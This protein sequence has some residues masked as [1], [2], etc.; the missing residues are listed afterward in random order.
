[1]NRS[2]VDFNKP[3]QSIQ[4]KIVLWA[5]LCLLLAATIILGYSIYVLRQ[6]SIDAAN[7]EALAI[8]EAQANDVKSQMEVPL[9]TAR[10]LAASFVAI[11]DPNIPMSLTRDQANA[12]LRKVLVDN[13]SFLGTY[14]AWEPNAF[15]GLD[16]QFAGKPNHDN[17][18]RFIPYWVRGNDGSIHV[19]ALIEYET[20]GIGDWYLLPRQN[21]KEYAFAPLIYPVQGKDTIMA[22]FIVP[23]MQGDQF[24]GIT[25]VDF[26]IGFVQQIVDNVNLYDGTAQAILLTDKGELIAVRNQPDLV[27]KSAGEI[28]KNFNF[29]DALQQRIAN[30]EAFTSLSPDGKYLLAF[31]PIQIGATGTYWS[32]GLIIP[33]EKITAT[34]T[35]TA[36]NQTLIGIGLMVI[37]LAL[38]WL[39]AS[40]I[41]RPIR[42]LTEAATEISR[43]RL[44]V[45]AEVMS[46]DETG[47]LASTFNQ[48]VTQ[49]NS[50]VGAL[51]KRVGE[52]TAELAAANERA[53]RRAKQFE[54]IA[55]VSRV[56][57]QTQGL[58]D[59]LPQITQ[60]ISQ[61]FG[62]YHIGIF[63][64]D[65][66]R[67]YAVLVAANSEGGERMLARNHQLKIGQ[68]GIVGNVAGTGN[69]RIALDTGADAIYFNNPDLP[70]TR[71]ELALPLIHGGGQVVGVLDVQSTDSNAFGQDDVQ[72][73]STLAE[74][75]SIAIANAQLY[76]DT[77]K[78]VVEAEISYRRELHS[79]WDK[80][81]RS[82]KIAGIHRSGIK[83]NLLITPMELPGAAEVIRSGNI[84]QKK[85][86]KN[87][88]SSQMTLPVKLRGE[89]VGV[90][91]VKVE[92]EREWS[93][94]EID[95]VT[96]ILERAA[97]AVESSRLL[98]ESRK[99]AEK[100]RIIGEISTKVSSFTNRNNI[101]QAAVSEI[102][103]VLPGAEV[104]I[105]LQNKD[106]KDNDGN[107]E[108]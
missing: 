7:R 6:T 96:A 88:K 72:V 107:S 56:I 26:P 51:E 10:T 17:T 4:L 84:Y 15:D 99:V 91:N 53:E 70:E 33:F 69:P 63:L 8:A 34:A 48:M 18:G 108:R 81:T 50:L 38:L 102:G 80:F 68:T 83:T 14:T 22:S 57:S 86:D 67:E 93:Q 20:P 31:S 61:Q 30:G 52:R 25:G 60:L 54:A 55:Q 98:A 29:N 49:I 65:A 3:A 44:D 37:M 97:L 21:K 16:A 11:K 66:N 12:M 77:Q 1:M 75:V 58:Q 92:Q 104:V 40:Q 47:L 5:G 59:L 94:D 85:S 27:T 106:G 2:T 82:Q 43:G 13:P 39:L 100:E 41:A 101:L 73:L 71:S 42:R 28:Y 35:A 64:L 23:V 45:K 32:F 89:V 103:R 36:I 90:L 19:E 95:V 74:Q 62:F 46:N 79:G 87:D 78:A 76:E 105:Q 24:Y 9:F